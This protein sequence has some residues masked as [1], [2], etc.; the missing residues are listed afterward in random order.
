MRAAIVKPMREIW[1]SNTLEGA[2]TNY[3]ASSLARGE[4]LLMRSLRSRSDPLAVRGQ[5]LV[6][7]SAVRA[8]E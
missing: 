8:V 7:G 5:G 6:L 3:G 2:Y 4:T 1:D